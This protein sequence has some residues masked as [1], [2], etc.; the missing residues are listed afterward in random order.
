EGAA[1]GAGQSDSLRLD[2]EGRR[3]GSDP[4]LDRG[5][6]PEAR[7]AHRGSPRTGATAQARGDQGRGRDSGSAPC[8]AKGG[9]MNTQEEVTS[10]SGRGANVLPVSEQ[11]VAIAPGPAVATPGAAQSSGHKRFMALSP[12]SISMSDSSADLQARE[13]W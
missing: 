9:K 7:R 8:E 13:E 11:P 4:D 3:P 10:S 12:V 5:V 6:E 1:S 2:G